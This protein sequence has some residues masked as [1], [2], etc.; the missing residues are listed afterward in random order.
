[1]AL[2]S[3]LIP[4]YNQAMYIGQAVESALQQDWPELE[5][6]V[7]DDGSSDDTQRVLEKFR[8]DERVRI[9]RNTG[10]LGRVGLQGGRTCAVIDV[11]GFGGVEGFFQGDKV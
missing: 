11:Q 8:D 4:T 10:N 9:S 2:V 5:V 3:I 6:I 1:M 7:S